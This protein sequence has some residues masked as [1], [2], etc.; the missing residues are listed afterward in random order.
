MNDRQSLLRRV[1]EIL[2]TKWDPIR[3]QEL[4]DDI[5]DANQDEF[6]RYAETVVAMLMDGKDENALENYLS[7]VEVRNMGQSPRDSRAGNVARALFSLEELS[8]PR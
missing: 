6:D 2:L 7:E 1:R 8:Q 5:R 4:P 3:L